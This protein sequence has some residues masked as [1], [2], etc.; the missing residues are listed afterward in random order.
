M[1]RLPALA[2]AVWLLPGCDLFDRSKDDGDPT[3]S[4]SAVGVC[5]K[6][7]K[8]EQ[9]GSYARAREAYEACIGDGGGFVDSHLGYQ[10]ILEVEEG[11]DKARDV[12]EKL[13]ESTPGPMVEWAAARIQPRTQRLKRLEKLRDDS[14][15][16]VPVYYELSVQF[17]T[18]EVG[19]QSLED[20]TK[21]KLYLGEFLS[22]AKGNETYRAYFTD[23]AVAAEMLHDAE[24]RMERVADVDIVKAVRPVSLMPT[25]SNGGWYLTFK[26]E[27]VA[28]EVQSRKKGDEDWTTG[29]QLQVPLGTGKTTVEMKYKDVRG[30]W[31]GPFELDFDPDEALPK[32]AQQTLKTVGEHNWVA[33]E[34]PTGTSNLYFTTSMV[35]RCGI[36]KL[37]Y[38]IDRDP[39]KVKAMPECD[40]ASPFEIK[41]PMA[42]YEPLPEGT[43]F[44]T[45]RLTFVDGEVSDIVKIPAKK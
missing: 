20:K 22:R 19:A 43:K 5:Q 42:I 7:R 17:S 4:T 31:K 35:Y 32:F 28:T 41:D 40:P 11:P 16:F 44:V 3:P 15:D 24:R 30:K 25:P 38:G 39:N 6:A 14:P 10:R 12:Y 8:L 26:V 21:E 36:K 27:E 29:W 37:E 13:R 1:H 23:Y 9:D 33:V 18:G 45:V 2:L 34:A